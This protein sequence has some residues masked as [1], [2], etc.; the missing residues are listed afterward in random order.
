MSNAIKPHT[1]GTE[2]RSFLNSQVQVLGRKRN[3]AVFLPV[4]P[5][6]SVLLFSPQL[7]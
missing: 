7:I 2:V 3:W 5:A 1:A 4:T 6:P